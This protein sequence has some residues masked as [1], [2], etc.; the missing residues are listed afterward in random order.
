MDL[1][2]KQR[3]SSDELLRF[4]MCSIMTERFADVE[5]AFKNVT[6]LNVCISDIRTPWPDFIQVRLF[7]IQN[8]F[9]HAT[10]QCMNFTDVS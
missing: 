4:Y 5:V 1:Q 3:Q 10:L 6:N 2:N 7:N 8:K 9:S